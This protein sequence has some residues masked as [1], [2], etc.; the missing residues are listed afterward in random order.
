M[1]LSIGLP[2]LSESPT[3]RIYRPLGGGRRNAKEPPLLPAAKNHPYIAAGIDCLALPIPRPP[4][5]QLGL[6]TTPERGVDAKR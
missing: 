6:V 4:N 2:F 1:P 3:Q 5:P